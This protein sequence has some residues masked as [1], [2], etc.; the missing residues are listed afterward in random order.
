MLTFTEIKSNLNAICELFKL[1]SLIVT[2]LKII[3]QRATK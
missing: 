2:K 3:Q 1:G